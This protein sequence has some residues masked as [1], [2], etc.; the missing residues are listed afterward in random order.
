VPAQQRIRLEH[1]QAEGQLAADAADVERA[2]A[3]PSDVGAG[4]AASEDR[5]RRG[6]GS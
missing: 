2:Y 1:L 6:F 3:L 5:H 4:A